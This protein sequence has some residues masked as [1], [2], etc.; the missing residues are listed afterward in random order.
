MSMRDVSTQK[1]AEVS[2]QTARILALPK[3]LSLRFRAEM[4]RGKISQSPLTG[5]K[6]LQR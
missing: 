3:I 2:K 6:E 5:G 1:R 4:T